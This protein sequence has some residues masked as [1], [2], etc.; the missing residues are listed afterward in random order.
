MSKATVIIPAAGSGARTNLKFNKALFNTGAM[1]LITRSLM[2]FIISPMIER[3]IV[4][5]NIKDKAA[6][7]KIIGNLQSDKEILIVTGGNT[8]AESVLKALSLSESEITLIHDAARPFVSVELIGLVINQ[9]AKTGAAVPVVPL[10]DTVKRISNGVINH[11]IKRDEY[12][13]AQTPQGFK[14]A[15]LIKAYHMADELSY[16]DDSG[17]YEKFIGAVTAIEGSPENV[18]I[19]TEDDLTRFFPKGYRIGAGYDVH[20]LVSGRELI[21]GGVSIPYDKGL[22]GHSDADC[23]THAVMDAL[24]TAAGLPD[25]GKLFPDNDDDYLNINSLILLDKV[26]KMIYEKGYAAYNLSAVIIAEKPKM[27]NYIPMMITSLA[28]VINVSPDKISI[29]A[30]TTEGLGIVGDN[31]AI[32]AYSVAGIIKR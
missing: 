32:A 25:I 7:E 2:P 26:Y 31:Q 30:T 16:T 23:L 3:I 12:G 19:T 13:A 21:L 6:I 9:A 4:A 10:T 22:L 29:A 1:P 28:K 5:V 14:T 20:R 17:I 24:L 11:T 27:S 15:D 8:R 18:K